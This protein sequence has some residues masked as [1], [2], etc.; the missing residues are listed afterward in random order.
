MA[1]PYTQ[2][3]RA[4]LAW[5]EPAQLRVSELVLSSY[6]REEEEEEEDR[7][8]HGLRTSPQE[9]QAKQNI[10]RG[11]LPS[12]RNA[13]LRFFFFCVSSRLASCPSPRG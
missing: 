6:C 9:L 11:A 13:G 10:L 3:T 5:T 4:G 2:A 1:Y 12:S 8:R 7:L